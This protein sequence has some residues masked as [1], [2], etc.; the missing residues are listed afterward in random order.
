MH[1][2]MDDYLQKTHEMASGGH[3]ATS[4][5]QHLFPC[6][7]AGKGLADVTYLLYLLLQYSVLLLQLG[8]LLLCF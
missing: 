3:H 8:Y 6:V 2:N 1:Y 7:T 5:L 4:R